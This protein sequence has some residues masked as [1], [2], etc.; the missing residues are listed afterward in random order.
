MKTFTK[1]NSKWFIDLNIK[2]QTIKFLEDNTEENLEDIEYGD[3]FDCF[4]LSHSL[5]L[6]LSVS[7]FLPVCV[8]VLLWIELSA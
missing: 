4:S 8:C 2:S 3:D 6:L 7:L 1:F 5:S